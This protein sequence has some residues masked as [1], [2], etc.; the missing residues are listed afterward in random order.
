[1][2]RLL[3]SFLLLLLPVV[4][5]GQILNDDQIKTLKNQL[6]S[7]EASL[8]SYFSEVVLE[9][10]SS[11]FVEPQTTSYEMSFLK[12]QNFRMEKMEGDREVLVFTEERVYHSYNGGE[13]EVMGN[14]RMA[15]MMSEMISQLISGSYL[16][17]SDFE[18]E[19]SLYGDSYLIQLSP[20]K[21]S[22]AKRIQRIDLVLK[23]DDV[24]IEE[25]NVYTNANDYFSYKYVLFGIK[26][27]RRRTLP[28]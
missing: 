7:K 2:S 24:S 21:R 27:K 22:L 9:T 6:E 16:N 14:V 20:L 1:M 12:P 17:G 10:H 19:Y 26:D 4:G 25:L 11:L 5:V 23:M 18:I 28:K 15:S 13:L 3:I 8:T